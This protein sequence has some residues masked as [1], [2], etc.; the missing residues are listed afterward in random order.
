MSSHHDSDSHYKDKL[1][2]RPSYLYNGT[3]YTRKDDGDWAQ[4][5]K[6]TI[7][8]TEATGSLRTHQVTQSQSFLRTALHVNIVADH[9]I[10]WF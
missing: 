1:V 5:A 3:H 6:E 2:S 4:V 8:R 9:N 7:F 10:I